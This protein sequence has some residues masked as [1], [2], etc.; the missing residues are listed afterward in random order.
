MVYGGNVW[1]KSRL[2]SILRGWPPPNSC[3][4]VDCPVTSLA[5]QVLVLAIE[6]SVGLK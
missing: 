3:L 6:Y 4:G 1:S 5:F 2:S